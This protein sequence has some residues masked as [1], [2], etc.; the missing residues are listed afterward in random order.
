MN[1]A[2]P[3]PNDAATVAEFSRS[4]GIPVPLLTGI[5]FHALACH[6]RTGRPV[7]IPLALGPLSPHCLACPH[8][9]ERQQPP[10]NILKGTF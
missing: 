4:N 7:T 6:I 10:Q 3:T 2:H 8:A 9:L 1:E 5:L